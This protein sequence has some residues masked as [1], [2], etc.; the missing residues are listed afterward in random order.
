MLGAQ[1]IPKLFIV[2]IFIT[3][4]CALACAM[5]L[6]FTMWIKMAFS[7]NFDIVV[8]T[9]IVTFKLECRIEL[10]VNGLQYQ[11]TNNLKMADLT[12]CIAVCRRNFQI[13]QGTS[14]L[15]VYNQRTLTKHGVCAFCTVCINAYSCA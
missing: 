4:C 12:L 13:V 6:I 7:I 14:H 8:R 10:D 1:Y 2:D 5:L 15:K 3:F 11:D 9:S